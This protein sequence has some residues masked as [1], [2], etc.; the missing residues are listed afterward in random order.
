MS[1]N[2]YTVA[3]KSIW[4]VLRTLL[5]VV[6]VVV[7]A[8]YVFIGAMHVSNI[9]VLVTEGMELRAEYILTGENFN[10]LT[11]Y[12]TEDFLANDQALYDETYG[13]YTVTNFIY[14]LDPTGI[15]VLPWDVVAS[16]EVTE[17]MLSL[18]GTANEGAASS[19]LPPWEAKRY[20]V[21]LRRIDGRWYISNLILVEANPETTPGPTPDMRLLPSATP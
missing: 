15:F 7:L 21:K 5:V 17:S 8:L 3:R 20:S 4:Y 13:D 1:R 18:S 2:R 19:T 6:G 12:F 11:E 16:M 10:E 9:Y 14:K